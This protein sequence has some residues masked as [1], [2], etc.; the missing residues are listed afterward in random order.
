MEQEIDQK[1]REAQ[2][3]IEKE[4]KQIEDEKAKIKG[5]NL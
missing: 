3:E 2:A 5:K 4:W 1:R